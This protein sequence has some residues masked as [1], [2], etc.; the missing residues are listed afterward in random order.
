MGIGPSMTVNL[1]R[2][3]PS[4]HDLLLIEVP[5]DSGEAVSSQSSQCINVGRF[6]LAPFRT[7]P[8]RTQPRSVSAFPRRRLVNGK[9]SVQ[10]AG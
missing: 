4:S 10:A 5:V 9:K 1:N 8:V 6:V 3:R 7:Q 2:G